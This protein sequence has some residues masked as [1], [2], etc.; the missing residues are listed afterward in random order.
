MT[1]T[2]NLQDY[3][4][5]GGGAAGYTPDAFTLRKASDYS[6]TTY[7]ITTTAQAAYDLAKTAAVPGDT[8]YIGPGT[9]NITN[10]LKDGVFLDFAA[11]ARV[12]QTTGTTAIFD[13]AAGAVTCRIFG[14]GYFEQVM[15]N[16]AVLKV[17]NWSKITMEAD[18]IVGS[19]AYASAV[20]QDAGEVHVDCNI[21]SAGT[22]GYVAYLGN[23]GGS[24]GIQDIECVLLGNEGGGGYQQNIRMLST[25]AVQS[26]SAVRCTI[27][28][29]VYAGGGD[30]QQVVE[31][32][33]VGT[34][35]SAVVTCTSARQTLNYT[36]V[37]R[38]ANGIKSINLTGDGSQ[39][40]QCDMLDITGEGIV[41][42]GTGK[43]YIEADAI[44]STN[45]SNPVMQ[46]SNGEQVVESNLLKTTQAAQY[47]C[48]GTGGV[49][50][51][52]VTR[53]ENTGVAGTPVF[54]GGQKLILEGG[55]TVVAE[56][57]AAVSIAADTA[58]NLYLY[59]VSV[60]NKPLDAD[61]T[62][63]VGGV[64]GGVPANSYVVDSNVT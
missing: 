32:G 12:V 63:L 35:T 47:V 2:P 60:A 40:V 33:L 3:G 20:Y 64:N 37:S 44:I 23:N 54:L 8:I 1:G 21:L 42:S 5:G 39:F 10:L 49:Q 27:L 55:C 6:W 48:T 56:A 34:A 19:N 22:Q 24:Y 46:V 29:S 57:T 31:L 58:Q 7:P 9:Y 36:A 26:I 38:A 15:Q 18:A 13:D 53:V 30:G 28:G 41:C 43:Q 45:A 17:A 51:L 25:G 14:F 50:R 16:L 61:I 11:G 59:G 52:K 4:S 62:V